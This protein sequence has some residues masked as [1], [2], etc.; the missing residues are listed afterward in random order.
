MRSHDTER[1][2]ANAYWQTLATTPQDKQTG[3]EAETAK[4]AESSEQQQSE[5]RSAV[6]TV[7]RH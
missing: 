7:R 6:H 1:E 4:P 3:A 5:R 2:A